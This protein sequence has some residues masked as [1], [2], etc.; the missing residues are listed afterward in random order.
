MRYSTEKHRIGFVE[1]TYLLIGAL[2]LLLMGVVA[3]GQSPTPAL[4]AV[5]SHS[6]VQQPLYTEY[7]GVR[8]GM[9]AAEARAKLGEPAMKSNEQD[10]FVLSPNETAQIVYDVFQKVTTISADYAGGVGAPDYRAVVGEGMLLERP[11]GSL[12]RM[13]QY[14][15]AGMWVS[16][17]RS[18][19]VVPVVTITIQLIR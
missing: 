2:L 1:L 7:R 10:Y 18:A 12:F 6:Q 9:T 11:D 5:R 17:N 4:K 14:P 3:N 8:L 13:A 15:S 16:Y 19:T